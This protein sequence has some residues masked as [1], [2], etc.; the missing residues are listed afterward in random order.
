MVRVA[1]VTGGNKGIGYAIVK[2]LC[3]KFDGTVYLTA[4]DVNR[5]QEAVQKLKAQGFNPQFHQLDVTDE[6]SIETFRDYLKKTYGG[7]DVLVNNAAIAFKVDA[8]EP[9]ALQA[10]ETIRVNYFALRKVFSIL[11]PLL[12]AHARVVH[13]SSSAGRLCFFDADSL[14]KRF[15][16]P[17]L[18]EEQ[19]DELMNEFVKEAQTDSH[20]Q[21]GWPNSAYVVSKVGV[22]ALAG[23]QQKL[24][25]KL[26][27]DIVIN[28]VHPGYVDTDMT[29][30][31]GTLTPEQGAV[32]PLF[33]A[34]L[35]ENPDEKGKYI[36]CDKSIRDWTTDTGSH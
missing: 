11:S 27:N 15:A 8:T 1:A 24:F 19:L 12:R 31:K 32:A 23:I 20:R 22:S 28:A 34:L 14:K 21:S 13:L 25:D 17:N 7:L 36:W 6:V 2:G 5:G 16:D 3:E 30:H 18:T 9:F 33:C 4:R 35:S 26:G 29:S 10:E